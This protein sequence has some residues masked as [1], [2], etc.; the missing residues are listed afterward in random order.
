MGHQLPFFPRHAAHFGFDG[1]W[2]DAEHRS[3]DPR[4]I[5]ALIGAHHLADI[6]C[7]WRP[8]TTEKT[9]LYRLLEDGATGLMIPFCCTPEKASSLVQATKFPPLGS[10]GVDGAGLDSDF[11]L[12]N[13]KDYRA[14]ANRE[15]FLMVQIE[16]PE[17]LNNVEEIAA[18]P[19]VDAIFMG[20]GDISLRLETA[21]GEPK[22]IATQKRIAQA[23]SKYGKPWGRPA[24]SPQDAKNLKAEGAQLIA[25]G[26]DFMGVFNHLR[27]S[28]EQLDEA[29]GE[30][31][32]P[33]KQELEAIIP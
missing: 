24:F 16:T 9:G 29:F 12:C 3:F 17:G 1:V 30:Q 25:F 8:A 20:P 31:V 27:Q 19:G 2:V 10:R 13:Q 21:F 26:N 7:L 22:F 4:E 32:L 23:A 6:D 14:W 18:I 15:T 11:M 5:Q 33:I 28:M